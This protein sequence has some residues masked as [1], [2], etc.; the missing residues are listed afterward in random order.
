MNRHGTRARFVL[1]A[2]AALLPALPIAET[3]SPVEAKRRPR[4]VTRTFR[5]TAP[6]TLPKTSSIDPVAAD[7]YPS[8]IT[9]SG[10][11][12][13]IRDVNLRLNDLDHTYLA[14][15]RVLVVGPGGQT[16]I[17]M[18]DIAGADDADGTTLRLDDEA[19]A[20]LP[21]VDAPGDTLL[22]GDYRPANHS[23]NPVI[24]AAPAPPVMGA[25]SALST[26]DGAN[27]NGTWRLFVM[28]SHGFAFPGSFAGG[29]ELEIT[30]KVKAKKKKR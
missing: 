14:E 12:G 1:V 26:F 4:T 18:A 19:K 20:P 17:V 29:W 27:P 22:S 21:A 25:N 6:I 15:V 9:V 16:A 28:D 11:K 24:F 23:I 13:A 10:L 30:T 5:N 3:A 2:L 7:L 8:P